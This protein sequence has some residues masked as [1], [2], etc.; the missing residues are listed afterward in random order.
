MSYV[1]PKGIQILDV[2]PEI[3]REF[4]QTHLDRLTRCVVL[5]MRYAMLLGYVNNLYSCFLNDYNIWKDRRH[6]TRWKQLP[7]ARVHKLLH[8]LLIVNN[9]HYPLCGIKDVLD[10]VCASLPFESFKIAKSSLESRQ[11]FMNT[12][13][14]L[15]EFHIP[16]LGKDE[17]GVLEQFDL[18]YSSEYIFNIPD[19]HFVSLQNPSALRAEDIEKFSP[20]RDLLDDLYQAYHEIQKMDPIGIDYQR[21]VEKELKTYREKVTRLLDF[22]ETLN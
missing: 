2:I 17:G 10:N 11:K 18:S 6:A 15:P 20:I 12:L 21:V 4:T 7:V 8:Q 9:F 13:S 5:R 19:E 14:N 16:E 3:G 1:F 22:V